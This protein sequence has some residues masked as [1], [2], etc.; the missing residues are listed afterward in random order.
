MDRPTS[1]TDILPDLEDTPE[2]ESEPRKS[3]ATLLC[4]EGAENLP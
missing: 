1:E 4:T 2:C 3:E